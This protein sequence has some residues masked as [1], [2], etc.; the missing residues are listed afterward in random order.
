MSKPLCTVLIPFDAA[1]Q[2]RFA[3]LEQIGEELGFQTMRV[4]QYYSSGMILE[5]I[6]RS[7]RDAHL[8][9]ADLTRGNPNVCYELGIA[10]ALGKRVFLVAEEPAANRIDFGALRVCKFEGTQAGRERLSGELRSFAGTP[11]TLSPIDL[12]S[13]DLAVVGQPLLA[14]RT[15]GFVLDL[16]FA[17]VAVG[18]ILV[19][20]AWVVPESARVYVDGAIAP[21]LLVYFLLAG[22][23]LS[24][25]PGQ[26]IMGLKV[27][28]LNRTEPSLWQR[29]F[30]PI[31]GVVTV[32]SLGMGFLWAARSPRHQAVHDI[33]TRTLVLRRGT[34]EANPQR[35]KTLDATHQRS[36]LASWIR[37]GRA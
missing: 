5:E 3:S 36:D 15:G 23:L 10:H 4:A 7:I 20:V 27:T 12:F 22:V 9:I 31:A 29:F 17:A 11:G 19:P 26:R 24:T 1:G 28:R 33:I 14:R 2:A 18:L 8:I 13:G 35:P 32:M 25:P 16:V 30:R 21:A 34:F 37:P 6:V